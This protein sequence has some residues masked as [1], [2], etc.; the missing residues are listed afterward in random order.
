MASISALNFKLQNI[1]V[2]SGF[3][4]LVS[5]TSNIASAVQALNS[6]SL[7]GIL[8]ETVSGIQALNT[9]VNAATAIATLTGNIP[10]IQDQIIK[11]VSQ[12]KTALD[13]ICGTAIDNGFLDVV[14]TCP[15]PE[16]VKAATSAIATVT[17]KQT[18]A[19]LSNTTPK[20]YA[21][22]IPAVSEKTFDQ[23][24]GEYSSS[25]NSYSSA[26]NNI[27]RSLTGNVL[28]DIL[29]QTDDTPISML[30]NFGVPRAAA[31]DILV[32][33]Q[34][35]KTSQAVEEI[36]KI[37]GKDVA[38]TEKFIETI[39]AT[40]KQQVEDKQRATSST[41]VFDVTSKHNTWRG[42]ATTSG[43]FDIIATQEQ[44]IIEFLKSGREITEIVFYGHEMTPD[45][46]LTAKDIHASYNADGNDG[47]PF[48]YVIQPGGNLQRGR[49]LS[50]VGTYST[51]H[52]K[53][54]IGVVI[55][56]YI[57]G[58]ANVQ[59]GATVNLILEAFYRVWPG[60]QVFNAEVDLGESKV[61]V[62]VDV[63]NYIEKFKKIN[64]GGAGRSLSTA[65]LISAAQGNV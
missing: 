53:Y 41:G 39:P 64:Y 26:F 44:L 63:S 48:H 15:T 8:N 14:I 9:T 51:T 57:N 32:L 10:G 36:V 25:L 54:S 33:L 28:Q 46:V 16:G 18:Q 1:K 34:A 22:Q 4:K 50:K 19:I 29:L 49:S 5:E 24:S 65:Q 27:S 21:D 31:A 11:D 61:N 42:A 3:D 37:T 20:K 45:Q 30:E 38:V 2:S 40:I 52:D 7:G 59:Q 62:G 60:G 47:I 12:S 58:N 23:F 56:H 6:T 13:A 55:P 35:K 43:Y 17:D